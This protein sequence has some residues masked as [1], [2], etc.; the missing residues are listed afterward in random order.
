MRDQC[1]GRIMYISGQQTIVQSD[2]LHSFIWPLTQLD[3]DSF[4]SHR[5]ELVHP[6]IVLTSIPSTNLSSQVATPHCCSRVMLGNCRVPSCGITS[7]LL[8]KLKWLGF[9]GG[10][11]V[12]RSGS[13]KQRV[14]LTMMTAP[15]KWGGWNR[16]GVFCFV[17]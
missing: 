7:G 10:R 9:P 5:G 14:K 4:V 6:F 3:L 17:M 8:P 15:D 11:S 13:L 1:I 12:L 16:T 2:L